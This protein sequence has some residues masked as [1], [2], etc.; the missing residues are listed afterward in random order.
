MPEDGFVFTSTVAE[1]RDETFTRDFGETD[2][3]QMTN[4]ITKEASLVPLHDGIEDAETMPD[5]MPGDDFW[6]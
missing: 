4:A 3:R 1:K 5:L 2:L 6:L